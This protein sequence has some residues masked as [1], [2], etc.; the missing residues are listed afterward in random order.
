MHVADK[1]SARPH[2]CLYY[3]RKWRSKR[4]NST[5]SLKT[6]TKSQRFLASVYCSVDDLVK[7]LSRLLFTDE[8]SSRAI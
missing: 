4:L 3:K 2:I 8:F 1:A 5:M 6:L 7:E